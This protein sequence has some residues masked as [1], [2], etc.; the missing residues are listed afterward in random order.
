MATGYIDKSAFFRSIN[1]EPHSPEQW[2]FHTENARFKIAC[3]GRRFGKSTMGA[4][5]REPYYLLQEK[6]VDWIVG[7]NYDLGEKEF[8]V[9][10]DDLI[11]TK[12]LGLDKRVRKAYNKR[13][14]DLYIQFPWGP[15]IEVRSAAHPETLVGEGLDHVIMS[16]AA[17]HDSETWDRFVRPALSD[18][19]GTATFPTTPEGHNWLYKQWQLGRDPSFEGMYKSWNFPS[20][21]NRVIYP[22][23]FDDPEIQLLKLTMTEEQFNQEIAADFSSFSGK[24]Y[25]EFDENLHVQTVRYNPAW[26]NYIAFDWGY[27]APL[28]AIEFQI[29]PWQRVHVWREHYLTFTSLED[30]LLLL[31]AREQPDDYHIECCFGDAADPEATL[32]VNMKFAPCVSLPEAKQNWRQGVNLVKQQLKS[33]QVGVDEWERPIEAPWLIV[34]HSCKNLI[35]EFNTYKKKDTSVPLAETSA[36]GAALRQEDHALDALRYGLMH[37]LELGANSHLSDVVD[38]HTDLWSPGDESQH[39]SMGETIFGVGVTL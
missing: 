22:G 5:D 29:D 20:W 18:K 19:R 16:E 2:S 7:P 4:R 28:A 30:H 34:D 8:R 26:P 23:G 39:D 33:H 11:V 25:N 37:T 36:A 32:V 6:S 1:Y 3:C 9:I 13:T 24:I 12:Q 21:L 17:K 10:W 35:R 27:T 15:R 14:G 31:Q 38:T